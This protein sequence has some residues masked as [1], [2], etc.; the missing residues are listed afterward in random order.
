MRGAAIRGD[1]ALFHQFLGQELLERLYGLYL[2]AIVE[3]P[4][5]FPPVLH[6]QSV[7][8]PVRAQG[9]KYLVQGLQRG[10]VAHQVI[11]LAIQVALDPV[12]RQFAPRAHG[13]LDKLKI[14]DLAAIADSD[15]ADQ[16]GAIAALGQGAGVLRQLLRQHGQDVAVKIH[17]CAPGGDVAMQFAIGVDIRGRVRDRHKQGPAVA[18]YFG[19]Q[20]IVDVLCFDGIDGDEFQVGEV[21]PFPGF[22]RPAIG[23]QALD[24][25]F[26][27]AAPLR[28][29]PIL[30][31]AV[32]IL[33]PGCIVIADDS[34]H[35]RLRL[36]VAN[37]MAQ[38]RAA[39]IVALLDA[40]ARVGR[41]K[42]PAVQ[43]L[44]VRFDK[45][46]LALAHAAA[47]EVAQRAVHQLLD[48]SNGLV[49]PGGPD[50]DHHPVI[51]KHLQ[52]LVRRDKNFTAV[53]EY[54]KTVTI[55]RTL[56]HS[57]SAL[58]LSLHLGFEAFQLRQGVLVEHRGSYL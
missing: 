8:L 13:G 27:G 32:E 36:A 35:L 12:V 41:D 10:G 3:D 51:G 25:V 57:L 37:G 44:Q 9:A 4:A 19:V 18:A 28:S 23:H 55:L 24:F 58:L 54:R 45:H 20:G 52:H 6:H 5:E 40:I 42:Q 1:H 15:L 50:T 16:G 48:V 31:H 21:P 53:V 34:Q 39:H 14:P 49:V 29:Q 26:A 43:L 38:D 17:G 30:G 33:D 47:G 22:Q 2:L 11:A 56:D 7:R 46:R